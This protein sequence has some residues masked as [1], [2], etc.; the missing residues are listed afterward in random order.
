MFVFLRAHTGSETDFRFAQCLRPACL[1]E[2][3]SYLKPHA[4]PGL[5]SPQCNMICSL[6]WCGFYLL[7]IYSHFSAHIWCLFF[8]KPF[9][10][11][12][13]TWRLLHTCQHVEA[14]LIQY[15]VWVSVHLKSVISHHW[16]IC[17]WE[18]Q[19]CTVVDYVSRRSAALRMCPDADPWS[20]SNEKVLAGALQCSHRSRKK[21]VSDNALTMLGT[22]CCDRTRRRGDWR[23]GWPRVSGC[24]IRCNPSGSVNMSVHTLRLSEQI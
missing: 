9:C 12:T 8:L 13:G 14:E 1:H 10:V 24:V 11:L 21:R 16:K 23:P 7:C 2:L 20:K 22:F 5:V 19:S 3:V 15:V 6:L 18:I 4:D 17:S